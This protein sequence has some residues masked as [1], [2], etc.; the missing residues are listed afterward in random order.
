MLL[1]TGYRPNLPYLTDLGAVDAGGH[2]RQRRGLS[3]TH[4]G[5]GYLGLE[6]QRTPS[7][8]LRGVGADARR[9]VAVLARHLRETR[10]HARA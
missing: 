2:P 1:A 9:V 10:R 4:P 6:W 7:N 3:V 5:L 8:T